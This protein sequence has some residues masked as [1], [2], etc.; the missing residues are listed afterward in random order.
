L[1]TIPVSRLSAQREAFLDNVVDGIRR[2]ISLLDVNILLEQFQQFQV[3]HLLLLRQVAV[4]MTKLLTKSVSLECLEK[5]HLSCTD[6]AAPPSITG[7][8]RTLEIAFESV[9]VGKPGNRAE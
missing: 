4:N 5:E 2:L 1:R 6:H 7:V 3:L 8:V 9:P